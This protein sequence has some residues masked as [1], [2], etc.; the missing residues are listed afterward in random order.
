MSRDIFP[1]AG[2]DLTNYLLNLCITQKESGKKNY[3]DNLIAKDIKEQTSLCVFDPELENKR[4]KEGVDKYDKEF[5]LPDGNSLIINSERFIL[6]EP[7][8]NPKLIHMDYISL[9]EAIANIVKSWERE[10]WEE[11]ISNIILSGGASLIPGLKD[12]LNNELKKYFPDKIN[13]K[14]NIIALSGREHMSWI[15]ASILYLKN[16]LQKGWIVNPTP[17]PP[18][19]GN[20]EQNGEI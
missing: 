7:L 13:E 1:I 9:A 10:N 11:L 3:V 19:S 6:S 15:G 4:I 20:I 16:Q 2:K 17:R 18:S 8:F 14:T 12:R 5:V